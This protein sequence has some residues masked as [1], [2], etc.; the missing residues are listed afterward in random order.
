MQIATVH[1]IHHILE[2]SIKTVKF[3]WRH[4]FVLASFAITIQVM[5]ESKMPI[6]ENEALVLVIALFLDWFKMKFSGSSYNGSRGQMI[7][8]AQEE[9][10]SSRMGSPAWSRNPM[11]AGSP[12]NNLYNLGYMTT[13]YN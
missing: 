13:K 4:A 5:L 6:I 9:L 11:K 3:I 8:Y 1:K 12:A 2:I 7:R 10:N